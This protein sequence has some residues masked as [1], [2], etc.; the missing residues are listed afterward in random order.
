MLNPNEHLRFSTFGRNINP[1]GTGL[2]SAREQLAEN[3]ALRDVCS[4][5]RMQSHEALGGTRSYEG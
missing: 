4:Q 5:M 2:H 3:F 1:E